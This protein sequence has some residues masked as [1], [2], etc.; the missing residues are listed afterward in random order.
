MMWM[1]RYTN[2]RIDPKDYCV[3]TLKVTNKY[4]E[5][6]CSMPLALCGALMCWGE[7]PTLGHSAKI[8][9]KKKKTKKKMTVH[10]LNKISSQ[11]VFLQ[12]LTYIGKHS[13]SQSL[14]SLWSIC[15]SCTFTQPGLDVHTFHLLLA[16]IKQTQQTPIV[17]KRIIRI[18]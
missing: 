1:Q 15:L 18:W 12:C 11:V 14:S 4:S 10:T 13:C 3:L 2:L 8:K 7:D 17:L 5:R 16:L 9:K 6:N